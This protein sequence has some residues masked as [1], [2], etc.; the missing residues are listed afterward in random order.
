MSQDTVPLDMS[1]LTDLSVSVPSVPE[2]GNTISP[3]LSINPAKNW[4]FTWNNYA[5]SDIVP[6]CQVFQGLAAKYFFAKEVGASG[7]PHLQGCVVFKKKLRP[8]NKFNRAIHWEKTRGTWDQAVAYCQKESGEKFHG[9]FRPKRPLKPLPCETALFPWQQ[10]VM[11]IVK[12]EPDDRTIH[13]IFEEVGGVGKTTFLKWLM[14]F[15]DCV[16]LEGKKADILHVA[17]EHESELYVYDIERS[18]EAYVSYGSIEKIKNGCFMS[19]K[20]EG[21]IVNRNCP[22]LFIFANFAPEQEKLSLDR[23]KVFTIVDQ[24]LVPYVQLAPIFNQ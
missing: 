23:W 15:H 16:P 17:A 19:G 24:E 21:S 10:S 3:S 12:E 7:T 18:L 5:D 22:H 4:C 1:E 6:L 2:G 8:K 9:G 11:D 20:Y 13:W 14:R